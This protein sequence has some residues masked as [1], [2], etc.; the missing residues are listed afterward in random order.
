M[1]INKSNLLYIF[2]TALTVLLLMACSSDRTPDNLE[3]QLYA[4]AA[5]D[6]TR[7]GATLRG[8]MVQNGTTTPLALR[9]AYGTDADLNRHTKALT[10]SGDS[11]ACVLSGLTPATTYRYALEAADSRITLRSAV[12]TFTTLPYDSP[13]PG[14]PQAIGRSRQTLIVRV[15]ITDDGDKP[16]TG[17]GCIVTELPGGQSQRLAVPVDEAAGGDF[18]LKIGHLKANTVY[19]V[20]AYAINSVGEATGTAAAIATTDS[21]I[22]ASPGLLSDLVDNPEMK[23]SGKQVFAGTMN[24]DDLSLLQKMTEGAADEQFTADMLATIDLAAVTIV[25]GGS[26]SAGDNVIGENMFENCRRLKTIVLPRNATTVSRN[27]FLNCSQ[28][29]TLTLPVAATSIEASEGCDALK[30]IILPEGNTSFTAID[31]VLLN[32]GATAFVWYP[33]AKTGSYTLP[34]TLKILQDKTFYRCKLISVTIPDGIGSLGRQLFESSSRL[35]SATLPDDLE[36]IPYAMF[37]DCTNLKTVRFGKGVKAFG[38]WVFDDDC[39]LTDL[40]IDAAEPPACAVQTFGMN[41]GA[42]KKCTVHV[43]A[44][45]AGKYKGAFLWG[46]AFRIVEQ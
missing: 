45:S 37:Y 12:E 5:T 44:G 21:I 42:L 6:I 20:Q 23:L 13:A 9:F 24:G 22:M 29:T 40:Y 33:I 2:C 14:V 10:L 18:T 15:A 35:L 19:K 41:A 31:D 7:N 30:R 32:A 28:L 16:L 39:P 38:N 4:R 17:T 27:A 43:P 36:T 25:T 11:V 34:P 26:H 46:K 1:T 8:R 3:P